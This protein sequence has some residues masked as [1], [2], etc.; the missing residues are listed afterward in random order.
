MQTISDAKADV[1]LCGEPKIMQTVL[2]QVQ[3]FT[4]KFF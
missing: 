1:K 3:N 4:K 2:Q